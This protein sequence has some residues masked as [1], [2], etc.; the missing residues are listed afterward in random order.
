MDHEFLI[1][2][3]Y[4]RAHG[5]LTGRKRIILPDRIGTVGSGARSRWQVWE[6]QTADRDNREAR[7]RG[8]GLGGETA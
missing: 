4:P 3:P 2:P 6:A 1:P 7:K 8:N 5:R